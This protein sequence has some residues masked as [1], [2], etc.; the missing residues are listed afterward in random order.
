NL[1]A[2]IIK[3]F[4]LIRVNH[5]MTFPTLSEAR[6]SVKNV[7]TKIHLISTPALRARASA[8]A[9]LSPICDG[10]MAL[11]GT[12]GMQC[13]VHWSER[14]IGLVLFILTSCGQRTDPKQ[15]F[16]GSHKELLRAGIEPATR[17]AAASCLATAPTVQSLNGTQTLQGENHPLPSSALGE[18]RR[19][20]RL[21][22]TKNY[23]I[24]TPTFQAGAQVSPLGSPQLQDKIKS[25]I[26]ICIDFGNKHL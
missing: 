1:V 23:H 20:V 16:C 19:S 21:L 7:L 11:S 22:V 3:T 6:G 2:E 17:Y 5:P 12:R 18:A 25:S 13:A 24:P 14:K 26:L 9:L 10:L 8:L 15:Q 4:F